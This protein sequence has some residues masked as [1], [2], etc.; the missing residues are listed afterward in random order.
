MGFLLVCWFPARSRVGLENELTAELFFTVVNLTFGPIG[1]FLFERRA[2]GLEFSALFGVNMTVGP[3]PALPV[4]PVGS[5]R[6]EDFF[7][8]FERA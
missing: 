7:S 8:F 1:S 3:S 2:V 5:S 4:G 6:E